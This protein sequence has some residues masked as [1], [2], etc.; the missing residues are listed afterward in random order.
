MMPAAIR[1]YDIDWLRVI[2]IG[3]LLLYHVSIGFQKWGTMIGF[4]TNGESWDSLWPPMTML[5]VWR[6]PILFF[7]SGMGVY[8]AI[9]KR[10]WKQLLKERTVRILIPYIFGIL[11]I[12]PL[13]F[14]VVQK[15]YNFELSYNAIPAHLWF[16]GNIF[17][18]VVLLLPLFYYLKINEEKRVVTLIKK[19]L[20]VLSGY[21]WLLQHS[22][23]KRCWQTLPF[24]K[25]TQ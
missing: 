21:Y 9:R 4:I 5:N 10:N 18:Y 20:A 7:V 14:L 17:A 2:A 11:T 25:C 3:L 8:F 23:L 13:Q 24:T 1:R 16:L 12:V 6:I 19:R 22:L 15:Y